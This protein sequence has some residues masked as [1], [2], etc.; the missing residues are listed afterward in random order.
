MNKQQRNTE[1][2]SIKTVLLVAVIWIKK[3]NQVKRSEEA[4]ALLQA[5]LPLHALEEKIIFI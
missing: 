5:S 3:R 2:F 1:D 4:P